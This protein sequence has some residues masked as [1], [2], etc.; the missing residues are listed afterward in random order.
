MNRARRLPTPQPEPVEQ[1]LWAKAVE[2]IG[3]EAAALLS[4]DFGGRRIYLPTH[5]GAHHP[6]SVCI[7]QANAE[8]LARALA[9]EYLEP[10]LTAG[11]RLRILERL[12]AGQTPAQISRALG[13][14]RRFVFY[15]KAEAGEEPAADDQPRLI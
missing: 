10:P 11:K 1:G 2:T 4:R 5:P 14:T 8:A 7:G 15:V 6:L 12:K 13:C 3:E 9:G